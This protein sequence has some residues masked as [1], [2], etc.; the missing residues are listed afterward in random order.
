MA[1]RA[2]RPTVEAAKIR[3]TI[4]WKAGAAGSKKLYQIA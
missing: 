1:G 3:C 2:A 4:G